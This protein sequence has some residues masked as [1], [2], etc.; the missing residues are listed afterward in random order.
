[1]KI[2]AWSRCRRGG[3]ILTGEDKVAIFGALVAVP[4][5]LDHCAGLCHGCSFFP[6]TEPHLMQVYSKIS[7]SSSTRR[8]RFRT[9]MARLQVEQK[10]WLA[11]KSSKSFCSFG[12]IIRIGR[13]QP[14][15]ASRTTI[16][17][18]FWPSRNARNA[19]TTFSRPTTLAI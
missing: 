18:K 17:P 7:L 5:T 14:C 15:R 6:T 9:G 16:L 19:L 13:P 1:M 11:S 3:G 4:Q 10:S 8:R 12:G 2:C